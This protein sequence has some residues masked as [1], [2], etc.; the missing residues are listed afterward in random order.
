MSQLQ[1]LFQPE[2]VAVV[3]ASDIEHKYGYRVLRNIINGGY[4]G[5]IYPINPSAPTVQDLKAYAR[6]A[7]IPERV[8][9]AFV[10]I[11]A[12]LVVDAVKEAV[13]AG[14][15]SLVIITAGFGETGDEGRQREEEI[16]Q[17]CEAA[18]IPAVG[19]NC[20]GICSFSVH[21]AATMEP[22]R[23][24]PGSVSFVSQ[25]G[26]YGIT[27]LNYGLQTGVAFNT[28]I[29]SGN[30]AVTRFSEYLEYLGEDSHTSVIM[31]YIESL[32]DGERFMRVARE[33]SKKKP[34]V[35]MKFG[36]TRK[37]SVAAASHTGALAGSHAIYQAAFRQSGVIEVTRTH[38]LLNVAMALSMQPPLRGPR[39]GIAGASGG[40]AV[41]ATDVLEELGLE[42]PTFSAELQ[43][44]IRREAG[45]MPYA[46]VQNP[47]DLAA[48]LRPAPLLKCADIILEQ[49]NIDGA[50]VALPAR[51]FP[52][53]E[54][55]MREIERM[56]RESGKP[57]IICY[58]AHPDGVGTIQ[59]MTQSI[60]V[61]KSPEDVGE[62]LRALW[63]YGDYL[64]RSR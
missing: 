13:D 37:G 22:L 16:R 40:F 3:G 39:I 55:T 29:S 43:Q 47:I 27:T 25:S 64:S 38:D 4:S 49:D 54:T 20:M 51:P 31:G 12:N 11:P 30:E 8:D 50:V 42:V 18:N 45:T 7:D 35:V 21:L 6:V 5:R 58:Y 26:T 14:V 15:R 33:V 41:A 9:L 34:I 56:Q 57:V 52:P 32:R 60:P 17:Y 59:S 10:I 44:R 61:Y 24:E 28:F 53:A 48:D 46:S 62:V 36:R 1:H 19:P 23:S 2:S 63:R